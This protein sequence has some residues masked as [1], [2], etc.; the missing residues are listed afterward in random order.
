MARVSRI[1]IPFADAANAYEYLE[2]NEQFGK[3][4]IQVS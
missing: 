2:S 4:V 1:A 3:V